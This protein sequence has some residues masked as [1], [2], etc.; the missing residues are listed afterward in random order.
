MDAITPLIPTAKI[1][2]E[3]QALV[4]D[5]CTRISESLDSLQSIY[6]CGS[7]PKGTA[8]PY[9]S[10]A[11]FTVVLSKEAGAPLRQHILEQAAHTKS[12]FPIVPKIDVPICTVDEV[13]SNPYDWGFWIRIVSVCI[14]GRDLSH[15]VPE[16]YPSR[17]LQQTYYEAART[18]LPNSIKTTIAEPQGYRRRQAEIKSLKKL[19]RAIYSLHLVHEG[20]WTDDFDDMMSV[21]ERHTSADDRIVHDLIR[22]VRN[23]DLPGDRFEQIAHQAKDYYFT[24]YAYLE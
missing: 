15:R 22:C 18:Q 3:Y 17:K 2:P 11:D 23:P 10:D 6:M 7:V 20:S 24:H 4:S 1:P 5:F 16:L 8:V 14:H 9:Q 19:I 21:I 13:V 12:A